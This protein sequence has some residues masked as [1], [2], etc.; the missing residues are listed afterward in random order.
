MEIVV[1]ILVGSVIVLG[2]ELF[3]MK[4]DFTE[5]G[6]KAQIDEFKDSYSAKSVKERI[7]TLEESQRSANDH[8][9]ELGKTMLETNKNVKL[10]VQEFRDS[11]TKTKT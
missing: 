3:R 7:D 6:F 11:L 8:A 1:F 2:F 9:L 5:S 4:R 10:F